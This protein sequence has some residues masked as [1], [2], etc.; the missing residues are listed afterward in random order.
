MNSPTNF[1]NDLVVSQFD[2]QWS[3]SVD[4]FEDISVLCDEKVMVTYEDTILWNETPTLNAVLSVAEYEKKSWPLRWNVSYYPFADVILSPNSS[5]QT[6]ER[7]C[8]FAQVTDE[9]M[10]Y[11]NRT[12]AR[13]LQKKRGRPADIAIRTKRDPLVIFDRLSHETIV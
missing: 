10:V 2:K 12:Y 6:L 11:K 8:D 4:T 9:W 13:F 5:K 3:V 7:W 1:R